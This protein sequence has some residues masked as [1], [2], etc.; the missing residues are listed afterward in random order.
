MQ[1]RTGVLLS[2]TFSSYHLPSFTPL[3]P[4]PLLVL[5]FFV[6]VLVGFG[7]GKPRTDVK[8]LTCGL[9]QAMDAMSV[10]DA[11]QC[12]FVDDSLNNVKAAKSLGW[13]S[14]IYFDEVDP[15]AAKGS[16][17]DTVHPPQ[18]A[19]EGV[20]W[21][22]SQITQLEQLWSELLL[23]VDAPLDHP[24]RWKVVPEME[25]DVRTQS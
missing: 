8:T 22:I 24:G 18:R 20:D 11:N 14:C 19:P 6:S 16:D 7:L 5:S 13:K 25:P 17:D 2:G 10:R 4:P 15:T 3:L 12:Y 23:P 1:T 21:T 9:D